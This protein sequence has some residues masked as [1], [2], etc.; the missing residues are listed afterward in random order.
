MRYRWDRM[1]GSLHRRNVNKRGESLRAKKDQNKDCLEYRKIATTSKK[2]SM[3]IMRKHVA[4]SRSSGISKTNHATDKH[5]S[6]SLLQAYPDPISLSCPV[7]VFFLLKNSTISTRKQ[8]RFYREAVHFLPENSRF[9]TRK[10]HKLY[11]YKVEFVPL[12]GR[13]P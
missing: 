2:G 10:R 6:I 1:T 11:R 9:S 12:P 4:C 8:R 7:A 13:K 5:Y 3:A